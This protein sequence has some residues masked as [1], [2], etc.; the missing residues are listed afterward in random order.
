VSATMRSRRAWALVRV[1]V[2][3]AF[4]FNTVIVAMMVSL[5]FGGLLV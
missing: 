2:L 5:P 3:F 1:N 4:T